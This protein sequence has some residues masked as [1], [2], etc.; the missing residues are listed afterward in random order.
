MLTGYSLSLC[1]KDIIGGR[2]PYEEVKEIIAGTAVEEYS[3]WKQVLAYYQIH[4]W[5]RAPEEGARIAW[6]LIDEGKISQPRLEGRPYPD[7]SGGG[8]PK[9]WKDE[10]GS[11]YNPYQQGENDHD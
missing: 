6:R 9:H 2:V 10:K 7:L 5:Y 8:G 1:V 3:G 11:Y 4:F